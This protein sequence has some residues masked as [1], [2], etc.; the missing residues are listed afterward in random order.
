[1]AFWEDFRRRDCLVLGGAS[2]ATSLSDIV[3][4]QNISLCL[5]RTTSD[6]TESLLRDRRET[7]NERNQASPSIG[8]S[9]HRMDCPQLGFNSDGIVQWTPAIGAVPRL[10]GLGRSGPRESRHKNCSAPAGPDSTLQVR[11][12]YALLTVDGM[13]HNKSRRVPYRKRCRHKHDA[14]R[15]PTLV[16]E[17]G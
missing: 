4:C 3:F 7:L 11:T 6:P 17:L 15:R 13:N 8:C 9:R 10:L 2:A 1:M 14:S 16:G 12:S 5:A